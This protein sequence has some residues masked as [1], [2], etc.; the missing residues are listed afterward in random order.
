MELVGDAAAGERVEARSENPGARLS[1]RSN[2]LVPGRSEG[3][4]LAPEVSHVAV[5]VT[6]TACGPARSESSHSRVF[7][8]AMSAPSARLDVGAG[9]ARHGQAVDGA[10]QED[11]DDRHRR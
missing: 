5:R 7:P 8:V 10:H 9:A 1:G 6:V 4:C 3:I 2:R 11:R